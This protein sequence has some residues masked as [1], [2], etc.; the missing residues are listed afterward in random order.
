MP[1]TKEQLLTTRQILLIRKY[2]QQTILHLT[3]AQYTM[4]LLLGLVYSVPVLAVDDEDEAL[5]A[6]VVVPP[7]R[8]DLVLP[9]DVPDVELDVLVGHG[10]HVEADYERE[11]ESR[12]E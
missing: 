5:G 7:E 8:P 4:E 11:R 6:G 12:E 10:L 9:T 3:V 2:Q 1:I